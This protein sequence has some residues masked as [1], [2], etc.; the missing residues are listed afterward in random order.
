MSLALSKRDAAAVDPAVVP[1]DN[2]Q[3]DAADTAFITPRD[4]ERGSVAVVGAASSSPGAASSTAPSPA[5]Q[6]E[7]ANAKAGQ[8]PKDETSNVSAHPA[9][10]VA[11]S[12]APSP[13]AAANVSSAASNRI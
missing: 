2:M 11:S 8:Q 10:S 12:T 4:G 7:V 13:A 1:Q 9:S 6:S 5:G 3:S